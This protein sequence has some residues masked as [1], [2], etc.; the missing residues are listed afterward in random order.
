MAI[1]VYAL[2]NRDPVI[3]WV[4]GTHLGL[5]IIVSGALVCRFFVSEAD[6]YLFNVLC[7]QWAGVLQNKI[8]PPP[9]TDPCCVP[10]RSLEQYVS[11]RTLLRYSHSYWGCSLAARVAEEK[12]G[13]FILSSYSNINLTCC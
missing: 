3:L 4:L 11:Y 13:Y 2:Y 8:P 1:R 9:P 5:N 12:V 6:G 7:K 10:Q